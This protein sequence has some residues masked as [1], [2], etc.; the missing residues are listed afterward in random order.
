MLR[1]EQCGHESDPQYRFCGMCGSRL[2]VPQPEPVHKPRIAAANESSTETRRVSGPSFLGLDDDEPTDHV[3]YLLEDE[4]TGS[5][6]AARLFLVIV[7][8]A[9][10]AAAGW[11]WR[12]NLR[13]WALRITQGSANSQ[14]QPP[15]LSYKAAPIST[16]GSEVAGS[17]PN[18]ET[19]TATSAS[20]SQPENTPAQPPQSQ[21]QQSQSTPGRT[22][23]SPP[24]AT[25]PASVQPLPVE[26]AQSSAPTNSVA[27]AGS[28]PAGGTPSAASAP[29]S[30]PPTTP[31]PS[32]AAT[33]Q[34]AT[35]AGASVDKN[36]AAPSQTT[37]AENANVPEKAIAKKQPVTSS[38]TDAQ[39]TPPDNAVE[40]EGEKY[41]YGNGVPAD[42]TRAQKDLLAAGEHLNPKA[43]SVLGTMYATGHCVSRDLP[44]AYFWFAKAM[45]QQPN[46]TQAEN[47]LLMVWSQMTPQERELA[48]H[49]K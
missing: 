34:P 14:P 16:S 37:A 32:A 9:G 3:A 28:T 43:A 46:N 13:T 22:L 27:P 23:P 5:H 33:T 39:A 15:Q 45:R 41:L 42:C 8:L 29:S 47:D 26:P 6:G 44:L 20:A 48:I 1:C 40:L 31:A 38:E 17:V 10:V 18:A 21:A 7:L 24:A 12:G 35:P 19:M 4:S 30:A 49:Q 25:Q 36:A 11:H 2:T